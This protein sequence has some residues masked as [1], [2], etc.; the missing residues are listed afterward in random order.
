MAEALERARAA[1][2]EGQI[3]DD[4]TMEAIWSN[5]SAQ[6][7]LVATN[8]ERNL[9]LD[10]HTVEMKTNS[11]LLSDLLSKMEDRDERR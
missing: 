5:V 6:W 9:V 1:E 2:R 8:I 10:E 4:R 3:V 11:A 7:L